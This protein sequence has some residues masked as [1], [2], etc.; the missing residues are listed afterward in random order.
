[1]YPLSSKTS[2]GGGAPRLEALDAP[3]WIA[4]IQIVLFHFYGFGW[5]GM[6]TQFFFMLSGFILSYA[7]MARPPLPADKVS[8]LQYVRK[9]LIVVYPCYLLS[10]LLTAFANT[11]QD[12]FEW[13]ILPLHLLLMQ[14]WFPICH[15]FPE[16]GYISCSAWRWNG[17][18]WFISVLMFYWLILRPLAN[19]MRRLS[20]IGA[21]TVVC[22][23]CFLSFG[24]S[25]FGNLEAES[26]SMRNN[27][28]TM[29]I[30]ASPVGYLHVFVA[31]IACARLFI[32]TSMR[33]AETGDRV[34]DETRRVALDKRSTPFILRYGCCFGYALYIFMV[35][36]MRSPYC[37]DDDQPQCPK[38]LVLHNGA[39]IP[40]MGLVLLGAAAG[41]DPLA[42][43]VF[44]WRPFLVLGQL[45][46]V[47]Y[48]MQKP[49]WNFLRDHFPNFDSRFVYIPTL[50]VFAFLCQRWAEIP[51]TEW[52]RNRMKKGEKGFVEVFIEFVDRQISSTQCRR[53]SVSILF[54]LI[55]IIPILWIAISS[56]NAP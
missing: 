34:T 9:R 3:R 36:F 52:Q 46:Y 53:A 43:W 55:F 28:I 15:H 24:L 1:M 16:R 56:P 4:S 23:C 50:I 31:G 32:L 49:V 6:W 17:E 12:P 18:A 26:H 40:V 7:E 29:T 2:G 5:G 41:A 44:K 19:L 47:Q 14:A 42:E 25:G 35:I 39:L 20:L 37:S 8:T 33:D 54:A 48:L 51:Y 30:K 27:E 11:G 21:F 45:S 13:A 38:N 22:I 10:I